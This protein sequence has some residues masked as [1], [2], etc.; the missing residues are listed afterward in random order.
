MGFTDSWMGPYG[1]LYIIG[2]I[3][4]LAA[5]WKYSTKEIEVIN[6]IPH[7]YTRVKWYRDEK[8]FSSLNY[9]TVRPEDVGDYNEVVYR[10]FGNFR[11]LFNEFIKFI[12][13]IYAYRRVKKFLP[14]LGMKEATGEKEQIEVVQNPQEIFL[15]DLIVLQ[16]GDVD[17]LLELTDVLKTKNPD[18]KAEIRTVV[19][20]MVD[21][22][23]KTED[24]QEYHKIVQDI[25]DTINIT[26]ER[27]VV[28][29]PE[30]EIHALEVFANVE[31]YWMRYEG[32][33]KLLVCLSPHVNAKFIESSANEK[34]A[35]MQIFSPESFSTKTVDAYNEE[36]Q[37]HFCLLRPPVVDMSV[38]LM[39]AESFMRFP[40]AIT[41]T[42]QDMI[43][44]VQ[45]FQT[46]RINEYR[47]DFHSTLFKKFFEETSKG[48][49]KALGHQI[50]ARVH[51][52]DEQI[53]QSQ[54]LAQEFVPEKPRLEERMGL[55][56]RGWNYLFSRG[57]KKKKEGE[58]KP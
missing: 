15:D 16:E 13:R 55:L 47:A 6:G 39:E 44:Y 36:I 54:E 24:P 37:I 3:I 57:D 27:T 7:P 5:C 8:S 35:F 21:V 20:S 30:D 53:K 52:L 22:L 45:Y 34:E 23:K 49:A 12:K 25:V 33:Q 17:K 40:S 29:L 18:V 58:Q 31:V 28:Y 41:Q 38:I 51:E 4:W 10:L 42:W 32:Q 50:Y 1:D 2:G 48:S 14:E 43:T 56:V 46:S 9:W 19:K 11:P 26:T